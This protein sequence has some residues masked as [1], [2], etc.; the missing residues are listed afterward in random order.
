MFHSWCMSMRLLQ[1][2]KIIVIIYFIVVAIA[3]Y[4]STLEKFGG[5]YVVILTSPWS[6][7]GVLISD[8]INMELMNDLGVRYGI[9][10]GG[11]VLNGTI[12]SLV[13]EIFK[14]KKLDGNRYSSI[15]KRNGQ[16]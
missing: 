4:I 16:K 8:T 10:I 7:L 3:I 15:V 2:K 1:T 6:L 11:A 14:S 12:F 9:I 5:I 13:V